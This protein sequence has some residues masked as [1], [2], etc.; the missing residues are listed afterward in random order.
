MF[1]KFLKSLRFHCSTACI[2]VCHLS[3]LHFHQPPFIS[4]PQLA[5]AD[6]CAALLTEF[7]VVADRNFT[8][9]HT[10]VVDHSCS[11][12]PTSPEALLMASRSWSSAISCEPASRSRSL[13]GVTS[14]LQ[15]RYFMDTAAAAATVGC[16]SSH[17]HSLSPRLPQTAVVA[18]PRSA[19]PPDSLVS[20]SDNDRNNLSDAVWE[21]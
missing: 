7:G 2:P 12:P 10:F 5:S 4:T 8:A 6:H 16:A 1:R 3:L 20:R 9:S 21:K 18:A 19:N 17:P 15:R 14:T 13:Y 11:R